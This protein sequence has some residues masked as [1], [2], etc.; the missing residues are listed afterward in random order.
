MADYHADRTRVS[1]HGLDLVRRAPVLYKLWK[2]RQLVEPEREE[3]RTGTLIHTAVLE[4]HRIKETVAVLPEDAPKRPTSAQRNAKKPSPETLEAIRFW[5]D[6]NLA[7]QGKEVVTMAEAEALVA[8]AKAVRANPLVSDL[9][10]GVEGETM[11]TELSLYWDDEATGLPC[12]CRVDRLRRDGILIDLKTAADASEAAFT[13]NAFNFRYHVQA[14]WYR[15]AANRV[16]RD[17]KQVV[18]IV[19]E[20]DPPYLCNVFVCSPSFLDAGQ[21]AYQ[22]DILRLKQCLQTNNWPGLSE[23]LVSLSLPKWA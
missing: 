4:P 5:N 3:F 7:T 23:G 22:A 15:D 9:L 10:A 17:V 18:F 2:E 16:G 20:K 11:D 21:L 8:T 1:K 13:R 19:V 6:F 12:R 14:A